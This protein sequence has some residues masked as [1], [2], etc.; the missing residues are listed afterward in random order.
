MDSDD[1]RGWYLFWGVEDTFEFVDIGPVYTIALRSDQGMV[2]GS[3]NDIN[4][5]TKR[6]QF[7]K[8]ISFG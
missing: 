7:S 5:A 8:N 6:F 4:G 2:F 3:V 1:C